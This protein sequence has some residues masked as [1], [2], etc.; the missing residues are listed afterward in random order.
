MTKVRRPTS[1]RTFSFAVGAFFCCRPMALARDPSGRSTFGLL[2]I[3]HGSPDGLGLAPE[4]DRAEVA[5]EIVDR[6]QGR[7]LG[8]ILIDILARTALEPGITSFIAYVEPA[9]ESVIRWAARAGASLA[10][11][12]GVLRLEL[13]LLAAPSPCPEEG[14]DLVRSA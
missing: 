3:W 5:I 6:W 10:K 12:H 11:E 13:S 8:T 4:S 7:G 14:Q 1:L 9:N 2:E